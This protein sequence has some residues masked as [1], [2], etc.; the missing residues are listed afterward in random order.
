MPLSN[1]VNVQITRELKR[2]R[3]RFWDFDGS[4]SE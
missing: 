1:I 2:L 3:G 4:R